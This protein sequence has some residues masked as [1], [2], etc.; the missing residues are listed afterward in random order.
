MQS[1]ILAHGLADNFSTRKKCVGA[2]ARVAR[3]SGSGARRVPKARLISAR[4]SASKLDL[5]MTGSVS[6]QSEV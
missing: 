4:V 1:Y 2:A 6:M 5:C 3:Q